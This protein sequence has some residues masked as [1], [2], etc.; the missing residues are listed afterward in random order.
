M[1]EKIKMATKDLFSQ[2]ATEYATFRPDYPTE[3]YDII[4]THVKEFDNAWDCATGNGQAAKVLAGKFRRVYATDISHKQMASGFKAPNIFYSVEPA[5]KTSFEK[6]Q[7]DLI[8]VAQAAHWF[9]LDEFYREVNRVAKPN[10][11]LAIWGYGL[12]SINPDFDSQLLHFYKKVIGTFWDE[13]R[14]RI[15]EEYKTLP[16][17]FY[18]IAVPKFHFVKHWN[19]QQLEG[20][21]TTWSAVQKFMKANSY[22][23]VPEFMH[24]NKLPLRDGLIEIHFPLFLR[25][26]KV[27]RRT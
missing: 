6:G 16:F 14:K 24:T 8:V 11:V 20:Y 5:E 21:L 27:N 26:G 23:P 13:E 3:L 12:L 10:C 25:L 17:P 1:E 7:F 15:D 18:E 2:N 4:F 22:N 19:R 9:S